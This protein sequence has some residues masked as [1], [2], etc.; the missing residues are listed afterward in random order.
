M[1][2]RMH[3]ID[4]QINEKITFHLYA[5]LL[6]FFNSSKCSRVRFYFYRIADIVFGFFFVFGD[7]KVKILALNISLKVVLNERK[8]YE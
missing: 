4:S 1:T 3:L 2:A 6:E 5:F 8:Q 7:V